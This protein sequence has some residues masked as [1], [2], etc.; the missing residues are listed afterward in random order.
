LIGPPPAI[1]AALDHGQIDGFVL[2]PPQGKLTEQSGTGKVFIRVWKE[3]PQLKNMPFLVL[4]AKMPMDD[5]RKRMAVK[6]ARALQA[7]SRSVLE[8]GNHAAAEIQRQFYPALTTDVVLSAIDDMS[9][10]IRDN[11]RMTP[12]AMVE[13]VKFT[14]ESGG[15]LSK[16]LDPRPGPQAFWTNDTVDSALGR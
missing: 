9:S 3:F 11:G 2:S 8:N 13:L 1:S 12:A 15:N 4:V 5:S 14:T 10:G 16:P 7:A 6:T